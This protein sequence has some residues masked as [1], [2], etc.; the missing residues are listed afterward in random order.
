MRGQMHLTSRYMDIYYARAF[1]PAA[2][3]AGAWSAPFAL[4]EKSGAYFSRIAVDSRGN[5][6]IVYTE[7]L[8]NFDCPVCY[9]VFYVHSEDLGATWSEPIDISLEPTGAAKPQLVIDE[10]DNLHV[11][12]EFGQGGGLG[13]LLD[14]KGIMYAASYDGGK[15]WTPPQK[16][17]TTAG[18]NKNVTLGLAGNQQLVMVWWSIPDDGVYYQTSSDRGRNWAAPRPLPG[19]VGYW[20]VHQGK[21]D[22][23]TMATDSAGHAHL[24][25]S[26]RLNKEQ[27]TLS[28]LHLSW[29]GARWSQPDVIAT[30]TGDVPE[31]PRIAIGNGNQ[32]HVVWFVRN[33]ADLF[34]GGGDYKVWYARGASN[35]PTIPSVE[36]PV[37]TPTVAPLVVVQPTPTTT[38]VPT[39]TTPPSSVTFRELQSE[40]ASLLFIAQ[41]V[42]PSLALITVVALIVWR[43]R[44]RP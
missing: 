10:Q 12:W 11:V 36:L 38:P 44:R 24:V 39:F 28:V 19:V 25:L 1:I 43:R 29:D 18:H 9:H 23:Y 7:N 16:F 22:D 27:K 31:W 34:K 41:N 26:G 4:T 6:H 33:Q 8:P 17:L 13:Q 30:Y 15:I 14:P 42:I 20:G 2:A 35:A 3:S 21:L 5:L 32:L 40:T 37:P